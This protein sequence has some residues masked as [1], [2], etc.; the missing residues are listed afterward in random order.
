MCAYTLLLEA[1]FS[2]G[3]LT[4]LNAEGKVG[5]FGRDGVALTFLVLG[6]GRRSQHD[7]V[8][9]SLSLPVTGTDPSSAV[10]VRQSASVSVEYR[11]R[12]GR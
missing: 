2:S 8:R 7:A 3:K 9:I 6:D 1:S 12:C 10:E 4:Y 11:D 5:S